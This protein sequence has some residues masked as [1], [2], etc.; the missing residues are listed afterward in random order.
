MDEQ[1]WAHDNNNEHY[2]QSDIVHKR[3]SKYNQYGEIQPETVSDTYILG[4]LLHQKLCIVDKP[5][6]KTKFVYPQVFQ[7]YV[8]SADKIS[9]FI[10][11]G[12]KDDKYYSNITSNYLEVSDKY[13]YFGY[14]YQ[15]KPSDKSQQVIQL[16]TEHNLLNQSNKKMNSKD[17][18]TYKLIC[19]ELYSLL[20]D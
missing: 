12:D 7:W 4:Q 19:Q 15:Q 20:K 18:Y 8:K 14:Y 9:F 6:F 3:W 11:F 16:L 17:S 1:F 5:K 13:D 10:S 2:Y